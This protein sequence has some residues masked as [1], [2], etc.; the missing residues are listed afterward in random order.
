MSL[1]VTTFVLYVCVLVL[2]FGI[3]L[4]LRAQ[5]SGATLSGIITDGQGGAIPNA[6]VSTKNLGTDLA[7]ETQ[8]NSA[9]AYTIP[10]LLPGDYQV[11]VQAP[12]FSTA[13]TN[14]PLTVG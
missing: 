4:P 12:G 14:V 13:L 1:K 6:T 8:T 5:V 9:G 11:S 7:T 10:N 2:S 3:A